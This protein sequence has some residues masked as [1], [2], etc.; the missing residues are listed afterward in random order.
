[1]T[2]TVKDVGAAEGRSSNPGLTAEADPDQLLYAKILASGM[3]LGLGILL[4]TFLVYLTGALQPGIPIAELPRL[5]E[6][7]AHEY[8]VAVNEEFLHRPEIVD[9]WSWMAVLGLGDYL[10]FIGIALLSAVTIV[11]Y[12]G[13]LPSLFRK[14]DIIYATIA[15]LEIIVLGLA[16]SGL[17]T[18]GH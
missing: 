10:N 7:S 3:Y 9:G 12:M 6:L 2:E 4:V 14:K 5:W 8:L 16:A 18:V 15:V 17:V 1:M 13:I 11:C